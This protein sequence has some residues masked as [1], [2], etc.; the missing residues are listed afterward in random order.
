MVAKDESPSAAALAARLREEWPPSPSLCNEL[1]A[2]ATRIMLSGESTPAPELW[3]ELARATE[4]ACRKFEVSEFDLTPDRWLSVLWAAT[5]SGIELWGRRGSVDA[6]LKP[7]DW[8]STER[9]WHRSRIDVRDA[10]LF[11]ES[12]NLTV[13]DLRV[14]RKADGPETVAVPAAQPEVD[15][16]SHWMPR[17]P[18]PSGRQATPITSSHCGC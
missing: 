10:R 6:P 18:S 8:P 12:S 11:H 13:Y 1:A 4:D 16:T 14:R 17:L 7:L 2:N 5:E 3:G 9:G 15:P